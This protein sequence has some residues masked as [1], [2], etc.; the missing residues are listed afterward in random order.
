MSMAAAEVLN[1]LGCWSRGQ[2]TG[3]MSRRERRNG[4]GRQRANE[5]TNCA[6]RLSAR[7]NAGP[8]CLRGRQPSPR[9]RSDARPQPRSVPKIVAVRRRTS[10][11]QLNV[12]EINVAGCHFARTDGARVAQVWSRVPRSNSRGGEG[13]GF[14]RCVMQISASCGPRA[15]VLF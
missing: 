11:G 5:A 10:R 8:C 6:N 2:T 1:V 14:S 3:H 12:N 15:W 13:G 9:C 4:C 7:P